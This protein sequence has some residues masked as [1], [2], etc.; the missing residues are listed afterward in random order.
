MLFC[1]AYAGMRLALAAG[2]FSLN[3]QHG[4]NRDNRFISVGQGLAVITTGMGLGTIKAVE[5]LKLMQAQ[6][7]IEVA[8]DAPEV[9]QPPNIAQP[10]KGEDIRAEA[11]HVE[12]A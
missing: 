9:K 4:V 6:A 11:V 2:R 3:L 10:K 7:S 1:A 5:G 8:N 12:I